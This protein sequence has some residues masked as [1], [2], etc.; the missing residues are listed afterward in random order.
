[1]RLHLFAGTAELSRI[2]GQE[3][4]MQSNI[5]NLYDI[6]ALTLTMI[7]ERTEKWS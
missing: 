1:M 7:K 4:G 6:Y 5:N 3:P 2:Y